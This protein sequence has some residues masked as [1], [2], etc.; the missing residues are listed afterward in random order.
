[1]SEAGLTQTRQAALDPTGAN[2]ASF[3]ADRPMKITRWGWITTITALTGNLTL[4]ASVEEADSTVA[5][6][7][8][9][10]QGG[11]LTVLAASHGLINKGAYIEA[12]NFATT[13]PLTMVPGEVF[14]LLSDATPSVGSG[15]VFMEF[16][17]LPFQDPNRPTAD[18]GATQRATQLAALTKLTS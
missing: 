16:E 18:P 2:K 13:A 8:G 1:M 4:T 5:S 9:E 17:P 15:H 12:E 3:Y 14:E 11:T 7:T 10:A 6:P